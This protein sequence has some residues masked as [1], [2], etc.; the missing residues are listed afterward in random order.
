MISQL[1]AR[2]RDIQIRDTLAQEIFEIQSSGFRIRLETEAPQMP[3]PNKPSESGFFDLAVWDD[4]NTG[5]F[6]NIDNIF[7]R[8][9]SSTAPLRLQEYVPDKTAPFS[10][11]ASDGRT[12]EPGRFLTD[13]GS[14]PD[15]GVLYSGI[16][17]FGYLPAYLI[18][19]WEYALHHC[20]RLDVS[21]SRADADRALL[22]ALKTMMTVGLIPESRR[23]FWRIETALGNFSGMYWNAKTPCSLGNI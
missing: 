16:D 1:E 14:I 5:T 20:D 3:D 9:I 21:I 10:F 11:T 15:I 23:D 12:I 19:D 8:W 18:H 4:Y 17:R 22:E 2:I 6:Q 13:G 7:L